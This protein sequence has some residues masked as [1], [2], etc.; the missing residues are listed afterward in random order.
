MLLRA[1][2]YGVVFNYKSNYKRVDPA[3]RTVIREDDIEEYVV[4][5]EQDDAF[6]KDEQPQLDAET[7]LCEEPDVDEV[8]ITGTIASFGLKSLGPDEMVSEYAGGLPEDHINLDSITQRQ[9]SPDY[10]NTPV[11]IC[12]IPHLS[13]DHP[14]G[15]NYLST[16]P[17]GIIGG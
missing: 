5:D 9:G 8:D 10:P 12:H 3:L 1:I 14:G 7:R 2:P 17:D 15:G 11:N 4:N 6:I 16:T 13:P